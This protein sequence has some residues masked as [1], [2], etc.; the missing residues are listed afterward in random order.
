MAPSY[1]SPS[2][3][4]GSTTPSA[5][6]SSA[7]QTCQHPRRHPPYG[8]TRAIRPAAERIR[9]PSASRYTTKNGRSRSA[10]HDFVFGPAACSPG[11]GPDCWCP[12][13][14]P[15]LGR[16]VPRVRMWERPTTG[17]TG[18]ARRRPGEIF[19]PTNGLIT[20]HN[21]HGCA[22][23]VSTWNWRGVITMGTA[24]FADM[25]YDDRDYDNWLTT[26]TEASVRAPRRPTNSR[27]RTVPPMREPGRP[28]RPSPRRT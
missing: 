5:N 15:K 24:S 21:K 20:G 11:G 22:E 6:Q 16:R 19:R 2:S 1:S 27:N 4:M 28:Q 9:F 10:P 25:G 8:A 17:A 13:A 23:S 26:L 14:S 3:P 12:S 7:N 18:H